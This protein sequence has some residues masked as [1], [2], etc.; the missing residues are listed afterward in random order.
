MTKG[1]T[2]RILGLALGVV[3]LAAAC[4]SDAKKVANPVAE[5]QAR[6]D[7][8]QTGVKDAQTSL[9]KA[10]TSFCNETKDYVEAIDRYGK[11]FEQ[12][13]TTVGDLKTAGTD[14]TDPKDSVESAAQ[15]VG[16]AQTALTSA[17]KELADAQAA[18]TSALVAASSA[19]PPPSSTTSTT[20]TTIPPATIDRVKAAENEF[21]EAQANV[22]D[23]TTLVSA[24]VQ[25]NSAAF[26]LEV[27]WLQL[28]SQAGCLADDQHAKAV[29]SVV[30]YTVAL[31]TDLT[32]A[33][34][35]T[36]AI[37]GIYGAETVAAVQKL[38]T[39]K[40]LPSTGFVDQATS[41]A[42]DA[43]LK[44]S[45]NAT[46]AGIATQV[47]AIQTTLKLAGYWTG[48]I[49]GVYTPELTQAL[50]DFQTALGVPPTGAVDPATLAAL[51]QAIAELQASGSTTTTTTTAPAS[52][53]SSGTT[54]TTAAN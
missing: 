53:S 20:T 33:G 22:T 17:E 15:D 8:A 41:A 42:L 25:L 10:H 4:S 3:L 11:L 49:D 27:T 47:T 43:V 34:Y 29:Q 6:V 48:P 45:A 7:A 30:D 44:S 14:L 21:R 5:A 52:S 28:L 31:Q 32:N 1:R 51:E 39:D 23:Q 36:A 9:D 2:T 12:P 26:A 54:T 35:Y 13:A 19:A 46:V 50:K 37:D 40:G 24:S 18:L 16:S 38:Q